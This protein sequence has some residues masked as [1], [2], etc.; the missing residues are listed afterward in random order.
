MGDC[1]APN[2]NARQVT[3]LPEKEKPHFPHYTVYTYL[4]L[5]PYQ[6]CDDRK[7]GEVRVRPYKLSISTSVRARLSMVVYVDMFQ[8]PRTGLLR[9]WW[10]LVDRHCFLLECGSINIFYHLALSL[11]KDGS[12][13][14]GPPTRRNTVHNLLSLPS[15]V[16]ART[17]RQESWGRM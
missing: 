12:N 4:P 6:R 7:V 11:T 5:R 15:N 13:F 17:A 14:L 1:A 9:W 16:N 3:T 8:G 2:P 10:P